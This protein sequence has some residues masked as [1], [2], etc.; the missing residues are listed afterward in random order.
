MSPVY[1]LLIAFGGA[2]LTYPA[3]KV[4]ARL[5]DFLTVAVSLV[6]VI[7]TA[8]LY[9]TSFSRVYYTGFFGLRFIL[10]MNPLSW[11][12][13][14]TIVGIGLLSLIYSLGYMKGKD[15]PDYYYFSLM[16]INASMLGTVVA[17]DLISFFIFW[18]MMSWA[19]YL[20]ISLEGGRAVASGFK[21]IIMASVGAMAMLLAIVAV[22]TRLETLEMTLIAE[23]IQ[24]APAGFVFFVLLLFSLNFVIIN[25]FWPFHF[26]LAD[27]QADSPAPFSAVLAAVL[28]RKGLYGLYLLMYG[29]LGFKILRGLSRG[30][31][32]FN[33]VFCWMGAITIVFA[34]LTALSRIDCK[35]ILAW[36]TVSQGGYMLLGAAFATALGMG[37]ATFHILNDCVY[38][39][40]LFF[41]AGA[42]ERQ[43]GGIRDLNSLGGLIRKMPVTFSGAVVGVSALIGLPLTSGFVSKWMIYKTLILGQRPF[44]A[45]AAL[46]GTWG[47][48]LYGYKFIH[49]IFLGQLPEKYK[50]IKEAPAAMLIPI[51]FLSFLVI[52]FGVL[53]GIPLTAV[54]SVGT[55][56]GFSSLD[57]TVWG[58]RTETGVLNT[59]NIFA[60]LLVTGLAAGLVFRAS[61]RP[62]AVEQEDN[63]AAGAAIPKER[64]SYTVNFY[65]P[66]QRMIKPYLHDL[67]EGL[68]RKIAAGTE[69]LSRGLRR[70]YTGDVGNY[71]I[72][73]IFFLTL[74]IFIQLKWKPW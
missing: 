10:R 8:S 51:I 19:A 45:L 41:V 67:A 43:T 44:L 63:Y 6:L 34:A 32:G 18:E 29:I 2:F 50:D 16:F 26:W 66:L 68:S 22:Y 53:P 4:S 13:A 60:A 61:R 57:V 38:I 65:E 42:V 49:H 40:L 14:I 52:L 20:L 17:G 9:G 37:G 72:Y 64:Y 71:V 24:S 55:S 15:R 1:L 70:I 62:V 58:V 33:S 36:A 39:A 31:V 27:V 46:L 69:S 3:G 5:R 7:V 23:R 35:K 11:F 12:F 74:M 54:N 25:A 56:L 28:V 47:A 48:V 73:I 30:A 59:V 21:Y